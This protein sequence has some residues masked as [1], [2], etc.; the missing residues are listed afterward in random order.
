VVCLF[1]KDTA[2]ET[3]T[4]TTTRLLLA[5]QGLGDRTKSKALEHTVQAQSAEEAVDDA[6]K[7]KSL[8]L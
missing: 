1:P 2:E 3:T 7:A 8:K 4:T 5:G 6:T